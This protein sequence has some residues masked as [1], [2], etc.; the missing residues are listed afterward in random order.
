MTGSI[1]QYM[2]TNMGQSAI[3][4]WKFN[5]SNDKSSAKRHSSRFLTRDKM[6]RQGVD[7]IRCF[8]TKVIRIMV[9]NNL[10][11]TAEAVL[12]T[13]KLV[14]DGIKEWCVGDAQYSIFFPI[15]CD[16]QITK[17]MTVCLSEYG[18]KEPW[19]KFLIYLEGIF[20]RML[21]HA[22]LTINELMP[23]T[24]AAISAVTTL[25]PREEGAKESF[26]TTDSD[27]LAG[28]EVLMRGQL[29]T[30]FMVTHHEIYSQF[31]ITN[32]ENLS[33]CDPAWS[34][35]ESRV[36]CA[37]FEHIKTLDWPELE[38]FFKTSNA[39]FMGYDGIHAKYFIWMA[40]STS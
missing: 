17:H 3:D 4:E 25:T 19:L 32:N 10:T 30:D 40:I 31:I 12:P 14:Y 6:V 7:R 39:Y 5:A 28:F 26:Q 29:L 27:L 11:N 33:D 15:G 13:L 1:L 24:L 35:L 22:T 2:F 18:E 16:Q 20:H 9:N 37:F 8:K 34:E 23:D 38:L 36:G 21:L